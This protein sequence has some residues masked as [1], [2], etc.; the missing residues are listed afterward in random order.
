MTPHKGI[1]MF[2]PRL[3]I[4]PIHWMF[5]LSMALWIFAFRDFITSKLALDSDAISYY[6]HINFFIDQITHGI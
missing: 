5:F 6:I 2:F 3:K 4:Q 1:L